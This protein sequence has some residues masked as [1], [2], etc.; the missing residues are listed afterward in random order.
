MNGKGMNS[1]EFVGDEGP[2]VSLEP[3]FC[4]NFCFIPSPLMALVRRLL[5]AAA[6]TPTKIRCLVM[7]LK[8]V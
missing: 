5:I 6:L 4:A 3:G 1:V 2:L 8:Q 7:N